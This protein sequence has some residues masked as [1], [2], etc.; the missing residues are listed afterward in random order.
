MPRH[1][2]AL[3]KAIAEFEQIVVIEPAVSRSA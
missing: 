2:N 3:D 1:A